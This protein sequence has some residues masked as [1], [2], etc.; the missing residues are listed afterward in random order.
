MLNESMGSSLSGAVVVITGASAGV[1]WQAAKL[2]AQHGVK[3]VAV[4]RREERLRSLCQEITEAGG[5]A[6]YQCGDAALE[7]TAEA[8][9]ELA[10][11]RFGKL[12]I[13]VCNAGLG[14]Y[15][16]LVATSADEYDE[17]MNSNMRSSFVFARFA[18]PHLIAQR[19]GTLLFISSVAGLAG[20]ANESVYCA[21]K[22]AQIGFAQALD[23]E[24]RPLGIK[25][26]VLCPGGIKT[27]F[28]LGKGRTEESIQQSSML[29][30][31]E[32]AEAILF[33]CAQPPNVRVLQMTVRNMGEAAR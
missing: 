16:K 29:E 18:A 26:G 17:L 27:E 15:K 28:A 30:A 8:A 25:V 2:F 31:S 12:D 10:V 24:L 7:Q 32:V 3:V 23:V 9:I 13:V 14:N 5:E 19:K 11:K 20:A 33:A 4:A 21:T 6:V 22:F 1:G